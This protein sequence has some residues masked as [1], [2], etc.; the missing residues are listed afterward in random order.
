MIWGRTVPKRGADARLETRE[1]E[2][3]REE[4]ERDG[5]D[6]CG[7]RIETEW[8]GDDLLVTCVNRFRAVYLGDEAEALFPGDP[9]EGTVVSIRRGVGILRFAPGKFYRRALEA[10]RPS[11][12][13]PGVVRRAGARGEENRWRTGW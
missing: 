4:A 1:Q 9:A 5:C 13:C 3:R 11:S 6:R 12:G 7:G 2:R 10:L 8:H